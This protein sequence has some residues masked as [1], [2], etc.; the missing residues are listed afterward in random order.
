MNDVDHS[1]DL[2]CPFGLWG[3][4][5]DLE[6]PA[7]AWLTS[8][9]IPVRQGSTILV[10]HTTGGIDLRAF[11]A[12]VAWLKNE[13]S[14]KFPNLHLTVKTASSKSLVRE[15]LNG[16]VPL[17]Y[18]LCH[19][20]RDNIGGPDVRLGIGA[21]ESISVGEFTDWVEA[22]RYPGRKRIWNDPRPLVF[23]NACEALEISSRT[24]TSFVDTFVGGADASG[25]VGTEV[26]VPQVSA[27]RYAQIVF[28]RLLLTG[29]SME[30]ATRAAQ[31]TFLGDGNLM[32]LVYD[33]FSWAHLRFLFETPE[34]N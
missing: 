10:A 1:F 19:G 25:V 16:D 18:F 29:D 33:T 27:M 22:S 15:A 23:I 8:V 12:H 26:K 9:E 5:F 4:G 17:L 13:L 34:S 14:R 31:L 24:V 7:S 6:A 30:G 20:E 28:E 2:L 11:Q 32:G 21:R 3:Y